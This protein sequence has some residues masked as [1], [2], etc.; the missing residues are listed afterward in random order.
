MNAEPLLVA[1]I[2]GARVIVV[3]IYL[4]TG[5][6]NSVSTLVID[7]AGITIIASARNRDVRAARIWFAGIFGAEIVIIA[8]GECTNTL[9]RHTMIGDGARVAIEALAGL[10]GLMLT[11]RFSQTGVSGTGVAIIA[12]IVVHI[13]VAIVVKHEKPHGQSLSMVQAPPQQEPSSP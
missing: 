7:G 3:T 10:K 1:G 9:A 2:V 6:A 13:A 5:S 11:T 8:Q 4:G 12:R